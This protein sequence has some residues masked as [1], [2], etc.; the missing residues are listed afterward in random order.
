MPP[1]NLEQNVADAAPKS[2]GGSSIFDDIGNS[3]D[4]LIS[5]VKA[6]PSAAKDTAYYSY[7]TA[8]PLAFLSGALLLGGT[9]VAM[10]AAISAFGFVAGKSIGNWKNG[11]ENTYKGL[12]NQAA[13]GSVMG[14][15]LGSIFRGAGNV[16]NLVKSSYG[17]AAGIASKAALSFG[18]IPA[19]MTAHEYTNRA[20]ISDYKPRPWK[21]LKQDMIKTYKGLGLPIMANF[22]LVPEYLSIIPPYDNMAAAAAISTSYGAIMSKPK[23]KEE[24]KQAAPQLPPG[25][26][27]RQAA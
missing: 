21:E 18:S 25:Y 27:R 5:A 3:I 17:A 22:A 20:L 19:F 10:N 13:V 4:S 8:K 16:G 14:S 23:K 15:F 7:Y 9:T 12:A 26:G 24:N 6:I 2:R 1:E 11:V